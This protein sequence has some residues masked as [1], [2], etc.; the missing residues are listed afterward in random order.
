MLAHHPIAIPFRRIQD[1]ALYEFRQLCQPIAEDG[2]SFLALRWAW[3][4]GGQFGI[5]AIAPVTATH[6]INMVP[7]VLACNIF[8]RLNEYHRIINVP[9]VVSIKSDSAKGVLLFSVSV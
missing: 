3:L 6:K 5:V 9:A 2:F 7:A 8:S 4:G 1:I